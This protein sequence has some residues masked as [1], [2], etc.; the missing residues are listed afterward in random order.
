LAIALKEGGAKFNERVVVE[1]EKLDGVVVP[2]TALSTARVSERVFAEARACWN[3]HPSAKLPFIIGLSHSRATMSELSDRSDWNDVVSAAQRMRKLVYGDHKS[4]GIYQ[5]HMDAATERQRNH[6]QAA[7]ALHIGKANARAAKQQS[8]SA[9][10]QVESE[11]AL[12]GMLV[13]F[14]HAPG[15]RVQSLKDQLQT[16]GKKSKI[17]DTAIKY[18]ANG[19][20]YSWAELTEMLRG[21]LE[22]HKR[23]QLISG[24]LFWQQHAERVLAADEAALDALEKDAEKKK[25]EKTRASE[26]KMRRENELKDSLVDLAASGKKMDLAFLK[27]YASKMHAAGFGEHMHAPP[28]DKNGLVEWILDA[29]AQNQQSVLEWANLAS[30]SDSDEL[31]I[32]HVN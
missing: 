4:K 30:D 7:V 8:L 32:V 11:D 2:D 28:A 13:K 18:Q 31:E 23:V 25:E 12:L 21:C 9:R 29:K 17:G 19:V 24:R 14:V 26:Y 5:Q 27:L 3:T 10:E 6:R 15:Q 22:K 16:Y 20:A 1:M